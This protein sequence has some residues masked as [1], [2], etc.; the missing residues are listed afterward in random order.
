MAEPR[1]QLISSGARI[2]TTH[3]DDEVG[4]V[5]AKAFDGFGVIAR[6]INKGLRL[7]IIIFY[8]LLLT[9]E[10]DDHLPTQS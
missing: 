6:E 7:G 4:G 8:R 5:V 1:S 10:S 9:L 2:V 3:D